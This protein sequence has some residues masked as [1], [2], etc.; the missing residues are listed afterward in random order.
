[1]TEKKNKIEKETED[2]R[3]IYLNKEDWKSLV[4]IALSESNGLNS[5]RSLA[6][7]KLINKYKNKKKESST[8]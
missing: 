3:T 4:E 2:R 7:R 1:M 6:I 5:S 8:S